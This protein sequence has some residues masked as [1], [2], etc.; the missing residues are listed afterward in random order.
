MDNQLQA[1]TDA[2]QILNRA[3]SECSHYA[4]ILPYR[5]VSHAQ[6]YIQKQ[7]DELLQPIFEKE[8]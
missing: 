8:Q 2:Y 7:A 4:T 5:L 1:L 3:A 6:H